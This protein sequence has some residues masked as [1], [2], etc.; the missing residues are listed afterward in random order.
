[1]MVAYGADRSFSKPFRI[2]ALS[3]TKMIEKDLVWKKAKKKKAKN[4]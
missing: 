3:T 1:M 4:L 2:F